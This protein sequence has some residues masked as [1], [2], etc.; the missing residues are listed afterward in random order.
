LAASR[1]HLR[2]PRALAA[3]ALAAVTAGVDAQQIEP[4]AYANAPVG[5]NFLVVGYGYTRGG[6]S[7]DPAVPVT[8]AR[9]HTSSAV[10]AYVRTLDLWGKSGK[11]DVIVPYTWLS[12]TADQAG[13]SIQ[14]TVNGGND[15]T[16]RWSIN[17]YG[18]PALKLKDFADYRQD[19]IVGGSLQV[20]VPTGQYDAGRVVNLGAN[21]WSFKPELGI[22]K[23]LSP[24]T[25]EIAVATT[26]F[27]DNNDSYG[28]SRRSQDPLYS[29]Q[30]HAI[31]S[32]RSGV[33]VALDATYFVGG[34][35]T[36][37]DRQ[38]D[39]LQQNWRMGVTVALPVS[40]RDSVKL[41][42]SSG[43]SS[44][45]GNDFDQIG[46]AWQHRWGGGL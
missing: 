13:A 24:W 11:F 23:D 10:L 1:S 16:F 17:F 31:Y 19:L 33:W 8:N 46:I 43:T 18:A 20:S 38:S 40:V 29:M 45:T 28:G 27:T 30:A 3:C 34:R 39:D 7:F 6:L 41:Y 21:R 25:L 44:R 4:R 32:F 12:G 9:F 26:L 2:L 15:P 35:T 22:S 14:R 42:A 37:G 5:V 36:I